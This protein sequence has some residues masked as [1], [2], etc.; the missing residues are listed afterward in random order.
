MALRLL[1]KP[2]QS[3]LLMGD[4]EVVTEPLISRLPIYRTKTRFSIQSREDV[5][6][7]TIDRETYQTEQSQNNI[8]RV[9]DVAMQVDSFLLMK[10]F[11]VSLE[12]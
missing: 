9:K 11:P 7:P 3:N 1:R 2:T 8:A 10:T 12:M 6:Q 4:I 5:G